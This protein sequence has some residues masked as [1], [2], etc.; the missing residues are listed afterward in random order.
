MAVTGGEVGPG[1]HKVSQIGQTRAA[2]ALRFGERGQAIPLIGPRE[3]EG[4]R[5]MA[6]RSRKE[7]GA[8][9]QSE[10]VEPTAGSLFTRS[11]PKGLEVG[12]GEYA[13]TG[14]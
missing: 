1:C 2:L 13:E 9:P 6:R 14:D 11:K 10:A 5:D 12:G 4:K 8:S 7:G 3:E